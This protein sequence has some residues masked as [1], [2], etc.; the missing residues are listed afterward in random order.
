MKLQNFL[1][2]MVFLLICLGAGS[3]LFA[4]NAGGQA[5]YSFLRL[6]ISAQQTSIGGEN[7]SLISRDLSL[8]HANPALLRPYHH[9]QL[10]LSFT[11]MPAGVKQYYLGAAFY[12]EKI[13][14]SFAA[15]V[16]YIGYGSIQQ[17]DPSGNQFGTIQPRDYQI[18]VAASR[19]YLEKWQYGT[20]LQFIQSNYGA[21][22]SSALAIN[23]G[24]T[25]FDSASQF[26]AGL[27]M[28]NM[29]TQLSSFTNEGIENLPFDL[30]LGITKRLNN[31]PLQF[32][33]TL[34]DLHR[35]VLF[36]PD[37]S[38]STADQIFQHVVLGAQ[39]FIADKIELGIGY[40]HLRRR[41]LIIPNTTNGLTG[42]SMGLGVLL[43]RFQLRYA[44]SFYSNAK[45]YHQ[46]GMTFHLL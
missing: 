10:S 14:T 7:V 26:Q 24:L 9:S 31:A 21:Y 41:E 2:L 43:N 28:K 39:A 20:S 8:A 27:V 18:Q 4:Q 40:N 3:T 13:T 34:R 30:Q 12:K 5:I 22:R 37:S 11:P 1:S 45:G 15:H 33:V 44:R 36:K 17:T 29:G 16:Q 25:Y 23:I 42:F 32:S 38:I 35:L 6:P 19:Q 46:M